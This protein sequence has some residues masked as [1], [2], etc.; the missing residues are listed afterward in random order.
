MGSTTGMLP[1]SSCCLPL[2]LP[3]LADRNQQV[4]WTASSLPRG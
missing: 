3:L 2:P 4:G 1:R